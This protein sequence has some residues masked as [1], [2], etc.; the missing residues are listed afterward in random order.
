MANERILIIEDDVNIGHLIE[1]NLKKNSYDTCL[2][3]SAEEALKL[4]E[5]ESYNL[6]LLDL[7]LTGMDGFDFCKIYRNS[8]NLKQ[9]PIIMLTARSEDADIVAGLGFGA[10]DY[11][12]KPFSPRVLL[13]RIKARLRDNVSENTSSSVILR[14]GINLNKEFH[15]VTLNGEK[16]DLTANEF[17]ILEL[18]LSNPGRVY[19]RDDIIGHMH[20]PGYAVTDRAIDVQIVGLRKKLGEL[21]NII[22]TVRGVG[23]KMPR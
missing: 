13:A 7:M 16:L 4:L 22:E 11:M 2:V 9:V 23:Y 21:A 20:G 17:S 3:E 14:H 12:T 18:F 19:S 1:F 10:D 6:I 15:E 8:A 5:K